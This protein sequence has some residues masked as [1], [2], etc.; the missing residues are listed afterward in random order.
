V[1]GRGEAVAVGAWPAVI[2]AEWDMS[3]LRFLADNYASKTYFEAGASKRSPFRNA[4]VKDRR[5]RSNP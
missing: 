1:G 2:S 5:Q 4:M 3:D